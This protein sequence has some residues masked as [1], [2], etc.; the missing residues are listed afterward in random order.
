M[1]ILTLK[2][3]TCEV[4]KQKHRAIIG[5]SSRNQ[6][7]VLI[8]GSTGSSAASK[9][10]NSTN[11]WW[12]NTNNTPGPALD[13]FYQVTRNIGVTPTMV[14]WAQGEEDSHDIGNNTSEH[15]YKQALEAIFN[16]IRNSYGNIKFYIQHIGRRTGFT[17]TGGVQSIRDIQK[18]IISENTWCY[19]AAEIYDLDLYDQVHL[20]D[21]AYTTTA[22]RN[23]LSLLNLGGA[24]GPSINSAVRTGTTITVNLSHDDGNDFIPTSNI[25]GFKFFGDTTEITIT[26]AVRI[27]NST[28]TITLANTPAATEEILYY[29]YDDM[30]GVDINNIVT[31]NAE[32]PMPLR[33]AKII[34]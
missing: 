29:G 14:L 5:Q 22:K 33:T 10:S 24:T 13:T 17:N 23:A 8:D 25:D 4:G 12:D 21:T 18:K 15:D 32:T 2:K 28:I 1:V 3:A 16:D 19:P 34:L 26:S 7:I 11:Y 30:A 20:T 6:S 31:D 27:D 9:T